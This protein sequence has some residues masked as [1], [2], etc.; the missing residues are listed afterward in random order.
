MSQDIKFLKLAHFLGRI[1]IHV[2]RKVE[3]N[4]DYSHEPCF[5]LT[6]S[7]ELPAVIC[8]FTVLLILNERLGDRL[9]AC[10]LFVISRDQ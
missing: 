2:C 5:A 9:S 3:Q 1:V 8:S 6:V 7:D 4:S 10:G